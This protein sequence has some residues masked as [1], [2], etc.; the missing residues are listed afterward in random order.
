[1]ETVIIRRF[2][3][4]SIVSGKEYQTLKSMGEYKLI[5]WLYNENNSK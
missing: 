5:R 2:P 3:A 1:M 4:K